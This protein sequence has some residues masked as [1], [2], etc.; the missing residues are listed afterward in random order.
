MNHDKQSAVVASAPGGFA[1][2]NNINFVSESWQATIS[3]VNPHEAFVPGCTTS[4]VLRCGVFL[5]SQSLRMPLSELQSP[6][7]SLDGLDE[8][9]AVIQTS[10]SKVTFDDSGDLVLPWTYPT[11]CSVLSVNLTATVAPRSAIN[12]SIAISACTSIAMPPSPSSYQPDTVADIQA[13]AIRSDVIVPHLR[14][15]DGKYWL[16]V[17]RFQIA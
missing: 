4:V 6:S 13:A 9:G 12:G 1:C 2:A 17:C 5:S 3:V 7:V 10:S 8:K 16:D 15:S 14:L 11:G